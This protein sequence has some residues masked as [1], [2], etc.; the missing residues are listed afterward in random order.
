[1]NKM[2][3]IYFFLLTLTTLTILKGLFY[4]KSKKK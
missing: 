2:K 3:N 4:L 1:M